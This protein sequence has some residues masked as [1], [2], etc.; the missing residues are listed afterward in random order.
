MDPSN[1]GWIPQLKTVGNG[2]LTRP[3]LGVVSRRGL[4]VPINIGTITLTKN[5]GEKA[6]D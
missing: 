6:K 4:D 5:N 2:R 1:N 3:P